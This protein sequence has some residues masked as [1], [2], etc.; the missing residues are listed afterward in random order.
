VGDPA[1]LPDLTGDQARRLLDAVVG[2]ASDVSLPD[3]LR[4]IV[5]SATRLAGAR[6]GALAVLDEGGGELSEF[7]VSGLDAE[8]QRRIGDHP[9][10]KGVLGLLITQ[11]EPVRLPDIRLHP[12]SYGF[13]PHHPPM[14]SFLGVPVRVSDAVFGN[15]YL[16]EKIDAP[17]FTD[18]DEQVVVALA[19]AAGVA[20][21]K[22]RLYR[23]SRRREQWL[24]AANAVTPALLAE[25][26]PD[27]VL[28]RIAR[29][30]RVVTEG[31]LSVVAL[32]ARDGEGWLIKAASGI[33]AAGAIGRRIDGTHPAVAEALKRPETM[34]HADPGVAAE[35][36]GRGSAATLVVPVA[37]GSDP[38]ALLI[39]VGPGPFHE[40]DRPAATIFGNQAA[41]ALE[42]ARAADDQRR[43]ALFE[44]RD[45]IARDLHDSVIQRLFG[46]GLRMQGLREL[47]TQPAVERQ[48]G[49][50]VD[51][52]DTTIRDIRRTIFDLHDTPEPGP[53]S[54]RAQL[55]RT[56]RDAARSLHVD[57]RV[58]F[59][60][61]LDTKVPDEVR[62]DV[63]AS[64]REALSNAARHAEAGLVH[65]EVAVSEPV[66]GAEWLLELSVRDDGQGIRPGSRPGGG[67][68]NMGGRASRWGGRCVVEPNADGG[69][70]VYWTVP[71]PAEPDAPMDDQVEVTR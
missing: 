14:H 60:G 5:D 53:V 23:D 32:P 18:G 63:L 41:L 46:T 58:T 39:V 1:G 34:R 56:I 27:E 37:L 33:D 35:L 59:T 64:L 51:D 20:V 69:T 47:V 65:V 42:V 43:L 29:Q 6:Y 57:P 7:I 13:P 54:L 49:E 11:P 68:A 48:L 3:V 55:L 8:A 19:A 17:E 61:P 15:L 70:H 25:R 62:D 52:L 4:R 16:A 12:N 36:V 40:V 67:L 50:F 30:A 66:A 22:A 9:T 24:E 28:D 31:D 71:L 10:G 2:V 26:G 21:E 38:L 44:E 45:R